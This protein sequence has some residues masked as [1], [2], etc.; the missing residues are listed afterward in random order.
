MP[1]WKGDRYY[2]YKQGMEYVSKHWKYNIFAVNAA[3]YICSKVN[4]SNVKL[5]WI[6][7]T[8]SAKPKAKLREKFMLSSCETRGC[9]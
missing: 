8:E 6:Y 3:E 1:G 9:S 2:Q 5:F 4:D 7:E